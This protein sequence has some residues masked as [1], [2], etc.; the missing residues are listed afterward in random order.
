MSANDNNFIFPYKWVEKPKLNALLIALIKKDFINAERLFSQGMRLEGIDESTFKRVLF[1]FLRDY[2]IVNFLVKNGFNKL[3]FPYIECI[4]ANNRIWGLIG[5][6]YNYNDSKN[7]KIIE[8]LFSAGFGLFEHGQYW[9]SDGKY[10]QLWKLV[11]LSRF[12]SEFIDLM[13]S[14]GYTPELI[15]HFVDEPEYD[16]RACNYIKSNPPINWKGYSLNP[17]WNEEIA[18]P[19][20]PHIGFFM[21][22][23][24]KE[25]L[26]KQYERDMH[27][28]DNKK[29]VQKEFI[30]SITPEEWKLKEEQEQIQRAAADFWIKGKWK[31]F[32]SN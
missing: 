14:Y 12:D 20:K 24:K 29:R 8:L 3:H 23:K 28:Y 11:L 16:Q 31:N 25:L 6:A 7:K 10:Y 1:E 26:E 19:Q 18:E 32:N 2:D 30:E 4:D 13:L 15:M 21:S 5:R 22:A 27:D 9:A 17:R